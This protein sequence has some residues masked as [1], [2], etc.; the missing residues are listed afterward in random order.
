MVDLRRQPKCS[1]QHLQR[2]HSLGVGSRFHIQN[3]TH[4][5]RVLCLVFSLSGIRRWIQVYELCGELPSKPFSP[6]YSDIPS[7]ST[8]D[9]KTMSERHQIMQVRARNSPINEFR[10]LLA[11]GTS[12]WRTSYIRASDIGFFE[13]VPQKRSEARKLVVGDVPP[14]DVNS[15]RFVDVG[16]VGEGRLGLVCILLNTSMDCKCEWETERVTEDEM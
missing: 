4:R 5:A 13:I 2:S 15:F 12:P 9:L 3:N 14:P 11:Y 1:V 6:T 8:P 7:N 10:P 16:E